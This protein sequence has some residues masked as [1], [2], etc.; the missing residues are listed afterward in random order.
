MGAWWAPQAG[1]ADRERL[2][3]VLRCALESAGA[4]KERAWGD[5][6]SGELID[7]DH[8]GFSFQIAQQSVQ[9]RPSRKSPWDGVWIDSFDD[10]VASKMVALVERGAPRDFLDIYS[11]CEAGL[12]TVDRC[13]ELW[14]ERSRL[15]GSEP[16]FERARLAVES[17]LARIVRY[18]PLDSIDDA[19]ERRRAQA[20]RRWY[21]EELLDAISR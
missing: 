8:R 5:V 7:G 9:L 13:W 14:V 6:V 12:A 11:V 15:E 17:H 2:V 16:S 4:V 3:E 18:R 19:D 1:A 10:L 20:A 21:R